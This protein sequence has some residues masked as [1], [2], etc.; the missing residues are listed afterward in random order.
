MTPK[1]P[2]GIPDEGRPA[3]LLVRISHWA[4][5]RILFQASALLVTIIVTSRLLNP[6]FPPAAPS[7]GLAVL[8]RLTE[9]GLLLGLY[10]LLIRWM[11]HRSATELGLRQGAAQLPAGAALGVAM[12]AAVQLVLWML[13]LAAFGPGTGLGGLVAGAAA[14]LAAVFE[15]LLFRA[16]LFRIVE[17]ACGTTVGLAVSA[18][19]FGLAH[20][21]NPGAT[22]FSDAAIAI[23]AGLMLAL[24]FAVTRNLWFAIGIHAGW[25]FAEGDLFGVP[26]SGGA[27]PHSLIRATLHGPELLTGGAFGPEASVIAMGVS[28]IVSIVFVV[29]V[30]RGSDWRPRALRLTLA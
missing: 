11:E 8:R 25:N 2:A 27:A 13:G 9:A 18:A 16:V 1:S 23:E 29:L 20:S 10:A 7:A 17:Q 3:G 15:E 22:L 28:A 19:T 4:L 5:A 21:F 6:V 30:L 26:V 24:A 12:M 14:F